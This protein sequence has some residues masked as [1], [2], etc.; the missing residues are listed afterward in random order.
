LL[1]IKNGW[2]ADSNLAGFDAVGFEPGF[3]A[4]GLEAAAR[5]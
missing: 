4:A 1:L 2:G 5:E 3:G